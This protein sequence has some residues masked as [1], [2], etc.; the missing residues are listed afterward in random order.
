[1]NIEDRS[2]LVAID[3][4]NM[5][6]LRRWSIAPGEAPSGLAID[7]K[8][9]RLFSVCDN[10]KMVISDANAG[11]VVATVPIGKGTDGAGFDPEFNLAFSSNGADGTLTIVKEERPNLYKVVQNLE[12]AQF[13][14]TM[15]LNKKSHLIYL[16]TAKAKPVPAGQ[17]Q[18]K[19]QTI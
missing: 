10:G 3:S 4:Q 18:P 8:N 9:S 7:R 2:E 19:P 14:K 15:V 6:V 17:P 5:K 16:A 11:K 13:A 1:M 12:T